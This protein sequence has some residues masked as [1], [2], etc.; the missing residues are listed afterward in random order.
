MCNYEFAS[1]A[2]CWEQSRAVIKAGT[3]LVVKTKDSKVSP[4]QKDLD[5]MSS[6]LSKSRVHTKAGLLLVL[7]RS[8]FLSGKA[9]SALCEADLSSSRSW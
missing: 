3:A 5:F 7:V 6:C 2:Q 1:I 9:C 8:L 4:G